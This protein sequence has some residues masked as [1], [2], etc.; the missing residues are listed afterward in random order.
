MNSS[1][2]TGGMQEWIYSTL[3]NYRNG[4]SVVGITANVVLHLFFCPDD[5]WITRRTTN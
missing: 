2:S 4:K 1:H 5:N 3:E